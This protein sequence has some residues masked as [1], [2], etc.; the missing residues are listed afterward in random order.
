MKT[1]TSIR[2]KVLLLGLLP[3]AVVTLILAGY[4][5][6]EK[7]IRLDQSLQQRGQSIV[8]LLAPACAGGLMMGDAA[9]LDPIAEAAF[10]N[11]EVVGIRLSDSE[12]KV[13]LNHSRSNPLDVDGLLDFHTRS[14][15]PTK[16]A[17][18]FPDD[19]VHRKQTVAGEVR[20]TL[21][22]EPTRQEQM[23]V[24]I[25]G[26]QVMALTALIT[27][28]F[29]WRLGR[30]IAVP[31]TDLTEA[32]TAVSRGNL[33]VKVKHQGDG[34]LLRL[35]MGFN[36]MVTELRAA[37]KDKDEQVRQATA[38]LEATLEDMEIKNVQFDLARQRA[39][40]AAQSKS[41]FLANMSHEIRTPMNAVLGFTELLRPTGM[42]ADQRTYVDLIHT[43]A[44]N[45]LTIIDD[46]LDFSKLESGKVNLINEPFVLRNC[47]EEVVATLGPAA[48][49]KGIELINLL[50]TDVPNHLVGSGPRIRQVLLNLV[51][52]A[53]KFTAAGR[54]VVRTSLEDEEDPWVTL[55]F[56]VQ[57]TG[58]GI[59]SHGQKR[60]FTAFTQLESDES[61]SFGGT[62]LGLV[63]CK[64][65]V[66]AMGGD[67]GLESRLG[68]GSTF[69]FTLRLE[70]VERQTTEEEPWAQGLARRKILLCEEQLLSRSVVRQHLARWQMAICECDARERIDQRLLACEQPQAILMGVDNQDIAC[71][72][73]LT[74]LQALFARTGVPILL[75]PSSADPLALSSLANLAGVAH[76]PK[77]ILSAPLGHALRHILG[78]ED[79]NVPQA[80]EPLPDLHGRRIL[81]V[82]DEENNRLFLATLLTQTG[83]EVDQT[84]SGEGAIRACKERRY[85]LVFMDIHM[86]GVSGLEA[87]RAIRADGQ[88]QK[89]LPIIALSANSQSDM[90][91]NALA[92]GMNDYLTKP[93]PLPGLWKLVKQLLLRQ[94]PQVQADTGTGITQNGSKGLP[95]Y[96]RD[97]ALA[98]TGN[99]EK[100]ASNLLQ[101]LKDEIPEFI[102]VIDEALAKGHLRKGRDAVHK[103]RG[104]LAYCAVPAS[105]AAALA[106]ET[107][108]GKDHPKNLTELNE[109]LRQELQRV[110]EL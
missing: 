8:E 44:S 83:A 68:E 1:P 72:E 19:E 79:Y 106:L 6:A 23:Q 84:A 53:I 96:R 67:I 36:T 33:D 92:A 9:L 91:D 31:I 65:L 54:V 38:E 110:L 40:E 45:L 10:R 13:V 34:E 101:G 32:V 17:T 87:S 56:S 105:Q 39:L 37:N 22:S 93:L 5:T 90:V 29:A 76:L 82:D 55:R 95:V 52:N 3:A 21:S 70:A 41:D 64:R 63:I 11:I 24:I 74:D 85:D 71:H 43:A 28:Y 107:A 73:F 75:L 35:I 109:Q 78:L 89:R 100:L 20:I 18:D 30:G 60:L 97:E 46:V 104:A 51:G 58:I 80:P 94:P 15:V 25:H 49:N 26:L 47:L 27:A 98:Q 77:P 99:D 57:D 88:D 61:R 103:L 59:N 66:E 108:L 62:G 12:G 81:V 4:F 16:Q 42:R 69:W 48:Q 50:Y 102:R 86:P 14:V 7:V 2:H